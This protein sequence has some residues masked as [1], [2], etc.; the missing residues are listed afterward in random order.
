MHT[1][2]TVAADPAQ[3]CSLWVETGASRL[4]LAALRQNLEIA[5]KTI[6]DEGSS[7]ICSGSTGASLRSQ[8]NG[9]AAAMG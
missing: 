3:R 8:Q 1:T 4:P 6:G 5:S 9:T 7:R 2:R